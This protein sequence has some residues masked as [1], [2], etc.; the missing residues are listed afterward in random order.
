VTDDVP[1]TIVSNHVAEGPQ[2]T[3]RIYN[4][5]DGKKVLEKSSSSIMDR[6]MVVTQSPWSAFSIDNILA[7]RIIAPHLNERQQPPTSSP[8]IQSPRSAYKH[9]LAVYKKQCHGDSSACFTWHNKRM[10]NTLVTSQLQDRRPLQH[11]SVNVFATS[12][13]AASLQALYGY[14]QCILPILPTEYIGEFN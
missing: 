2:E 6:S 8:R 1:E 10:E 11:S 5:L 12:Q 13:P 3:A 7:P 14:P 9:D 4:N